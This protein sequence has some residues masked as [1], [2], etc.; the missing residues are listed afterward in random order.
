VSRLRDRVAT[1]ILGGDAVLIPNRLDLRL[2]YSFSSAV[3]RVLAFNPFTPTTA[4]AIAVDFPAVRQRIHQFETTLRYHLG[5]GWSAG[6]RYTF[7]AFRH[8]DFQTDV[9]QPW[10][11]GVDSAAANSI[12][13]GARIP[14]YT[15]HIVSA[16]VRYRF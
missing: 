11:G 6:L 1:W 2:A 8:D 16:L 12:F 4:A 5:A 9:M 3:G 15:A 13:L 7:E 14:D 10:M